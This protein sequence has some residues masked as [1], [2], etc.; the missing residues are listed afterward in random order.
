MGST[1]AATPRR[2]G[3]VQLRRARAADDPH[4]AEPPAGDAYRRRPHGEHVLR[5]ATRGVG[6]YKLENAV[7]PQLESAWFQPLSL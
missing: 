3:A 5:V 6:L 2:A 4:D 1:C 7:Y